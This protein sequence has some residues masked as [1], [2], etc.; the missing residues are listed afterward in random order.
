MI[1]INKN[2][3]FLFWIFVI[4]LLLPFI[5]RAQNVSV[6]G[7]DIL[8]RE[9]LF[10]ISSYT[11]SGNV[12]AKLG[13]ECQQ[14]KTYDAADY[15]DCANLTNTGDI[16]K[17]ADNKSLA[18]NLKSSISYKFTVT[19]QGNYIFKI[20]ASNDQ[21]NFTKL[22][23]QQIDYILTAVGT[24]LAGLLSYVGEGITQ[25]DLSLIATK[26]DQLYQLVR[27]QVYSVY[28]DGEAEENK[29][30]FIFIKNTDASQMQDGQVKIGN[31]VPG[32]HTIY[33]H[34]LSDFYY[35][36]RNQTDLP[37]FLNEFKNA[38]LN[39]DKILDTNPIIY[40]E[41]IDTITPADDVIGIRIYSNQEHLDVA[42][43]Y[44]ENVINPSV[45]TESITV[46]GYQAIRDDRTVY[47]NAPNIQETQ[48]AAGATA[49][50]FFTNIYVMAY[51]QAAP[52][53]TE[54]IFN[55]MLNNWVFNTNITSAETKDKLRRD[56]SRLVDLNNID[57]LLQKYYQVHGKYP[58]LDAGTFVKGHTISTW[59]SWQATL[60]NELGS[61]L[62]VD[63][64]NIMAAE[65]RKTYDCNSEDPIEKANC[66]NI[67]TR[68][69][70]N[71][72]LTGCPTNQQ[73]VAD[74]YCSICPAPYNAETCWDA[75][76][77]KFTS[78]TFDKPG[79]SQK[80]SIG[81]YSNCCPAAGCLNDDAKLNGSFNLGG[82][83]CADQIIK[84]EAY[85]GA[86]VYQ[87]TSLDNGKSYHL[88]YRLEYTE[89][90]V[91]SPNQCYF[92][93]GDSDP[94]NDCYNPG[95]CLAN[96]TLNDC[97]FPQY[98]NTYCYL[99]NW[100][101]SCGDGFIQSQ[102]GESCDPN[103]A[104]PEGQSWCDQQYGQQDWYY[105]NNI[106]PVCTATCNLEG[107][108]YTPLP[109]APQTEVISCGGFCGD[110]VTQLKY[111]EQCDEGINP[112][113]IKRPDQGGTAGLSQTSQYVCSGKV[114][115]KP[116]AFDGAACTGYAPWD[117]TGYS[118]C[119]PA[120]DWV[121]KYDDTN[122]IL[123]MGGFKADYKFTLEKGSNL[124][125]RI[126]ASNFGDDLTKLSTDQID[127]L[128]EL[129]KN[130]QDN[131]YNL[132]AEG[133]LMV[134]EYN[135]DYGEIPSND[136]QKYSLLRSLIF[137]VYLDDDYQNADNPGQRIGYL[138][139][140]AANEK[141]PQL[142]TIS[143]GNVDAGEHNLYLHFISDHFYLPFGDLTLPDYLNNFTNADLDGNKILD[144]N[145]MLNS[146]EIFSPEL[147]VG[148]CKSY[149]G[150]CGDGIL[151]MD[152]GEQCDIKGY[153]APQPAETSNIIKNS[154]FEKIFSPWETF[155]K[156]NIDPVVFYSGRSSL[157]LNTENET[158][159]WLSQYN[160][161]FATKP[162]N[163]SLRVKPRSG[164]LTNISFQTSSQT[165]DEEW[166]SVEALDF[167]APDLAEQKN[168]WDLYQA[169]FT[170]GQNTTKIRIFFATEP[171]TIFNLD[172]IKIIPMDPT[173]RPQYQ[174]GKDTNT[175]KICQYKG[176]SCGD[177]QIQRA[178]SEVCDDRLG[179]SCANGEGCGSTGSCVNGV[180]TSNKC[181]EMCKSTYCG[182]GIVQT[183]NSLGVNEICD[184]ATDP[185]CTLDCK[186]IKM[187]GSC[188]SAKPC[189]SNL[190]CAI[191][192]FGDTDT[193]CLGERGSFGCKENTNCILGYYCDVSSTKCEP[194]IATYLRY[195]PEKETALTLPAP[196][197]ANVSYRINN[198]V[199]P[200]FT[201][202]TTAQGTT[203]LLDT[204]TGIIWHSADNISK[205][206]WTYNDAQVTGCG[207]G[208][209]L[210]SINE[211]YSLVR[212]TSKGLLYAEET[213]KLCPLKCAYDEKKE[214]LCSDC[215]DD[216]YLYWSSTCVNKDSNGN[217]TKALALN[218]KYGS[219]EQYD[220]N[221]GLKIHCLQEARCGNGEL[222]QGE[223]CEFYVGAD[224]T[225][226]EQTINQ[227]C[228]QFGYDA[229]FLHCDPITCTLR[230]ENCLLFSQPN[231]TCAEICQSRKNSTCASVGLNADSYSD[232]YNIPTRE[233]S[234][235]DD[236]KMMGIDT[237]GECLV[238][239][240]PG[241]SQLDYCAYRFVDKG[242]ICTD[243]ATNLQAPF[244][245]EYSYCNC[246]EQKGV[247]YVAHICTGA[248]PFNATMCTDDNRD[249]KVDT[250]RMV[251]DNCS[252]AVKCEYMCNPGY[253][254]VGNTCVSTF[255]CQGNDPLNATLCAGSDTNLTIDTAKTT[256]D[257]CTGA[258]CEYVCNSGYTA[259][260]T[261]CKLIISTCANWPANATL[262]PA[263][264]DNTA[265]KLVASC[266]TA[267]CEYTCDSGYNLSGGVCVA[268]TSCT[269]P[270]AL[271]TLCP[272][273]ADNTAAVL[274]GSCGTAK[275][276]YTCDSGYTIN[277]AGTSCVVPVPTAIFS[278]V[279]YAPGALSFHI[280]IDN[281]AGYSADSL[282]SVTCTYLFNDI[283]QGYLNCVLNQLIS[284]TTIDNDESCDTPELAAGES[285]NCTI[286]TSPS[287]TTGGFT[288]TVPQQ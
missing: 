157:E 111:G 30:G 52:P 55:Q 284:G 82:T 45:A 256:V 69:A 201:V 183:P 153:V 178:F 40:G 6:T 97:A 128:Y 287:E 282:M 85:D 122:N 255:S 135:E 263:G 15:N 204:C 170:P 156:A 268:A 77:S 115:G 264:A 191:R 211:L 123:A 227:K 130:G 200:A 125:V 285:L 281:P 103:V 117:A 73:C 136:P 148:S 207:E 113:P 28:V 99:G 176:G 188:S 62:P 139:L 105:E 75:V 49:K 149:G 4:F 180:C 90:E 114:G 131:L 140:P 179:L 206:N 101:N 91:C 17:M 112:G 107:F 41:G 266:G 58:T 44:Q 64:L 109:Y 31:L 88:N 223:S 2:K 277:G 238:E 59:P 35:D 50:Q 213:L 51:N 208:S 220:V 175:G 224:G 163:I 279:V 126:K 219:V 248:V 202:I 120:S 26:D 198:S 218:F 190:S 216:N 288:H 43:W 271:A 79:T 276:E 70:E 11:E 242:N 47:V 184:Y 237:G 186:Q 83:N 21:D 246:V 66:V 144:I 250:L 254:R 165:G 68:D 261:A 16:K 252:D 235:A 87:Y 259:D 193:I 71:K 129:K 275:C 10:P 19:K 141:N 205:A 236:G 212:Q 7:K 158:S 286:S 104:L 280:H 81:T 230:A 169:T 161:L 8:L 60:G 210:P 74:K 127:Y 20:T 61:G 65:N 14:F 95:S 231:K 86:Y 118:A 54:N 174:C 164:Q 5:L 196:A 203:L 92:D 247:S 137:S 199:C 225:M 53:P 234:I 78:G 57:N 42:S 38:D 181:N 108:N 145:P 152:Y 283:V 251:V 221:T 195:H 245:S 185:Y 147:N 155:S 32:D 110:Q 12:I 258:K 260:G 270:P 22:T 187:G 106:K 36:F 25:N 197:P 257:S 138:I 215:A 278:N 243:T 146:V 134:P 166:Q 226:I 116:I 142:G 89:K 121:N 249:L 189:A 167:S 93:N 253:V 39:N 18:L 76:N 214:N 217:C 160:N 34:Y 229:G 33:L 24:D 98:K 269:N 29:K 267:K 94:T 159:A 154:G 194:E 102:C 262:C 132:T 209:R 143:L 273:G 133:G 96:C 80:Y 244:K 265:A 1:K 119:P 63:P 124:S 177:G 182:D 272:A 239:N 192:N 228:T 9:Y 48:T 222:E 3:T 240:V 27:S 150:W 232:I 151:Q 168:G 241:T 172:E 173:T 37:D 46:D 100:R 23:R 274:V 233:L 162:Y 67:C 72:P 56:M 84:P 171:N 13:F